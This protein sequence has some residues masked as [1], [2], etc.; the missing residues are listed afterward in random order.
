MLRS[1]SRDFLMQSFTLIPPCW[2]R[3]KLINWSAVC[4]VNRDPFSWVMIATGMQSI[5]SM[6]SKLV[7]IKSTKANQ[8]VRFNTSEKKEEIID[9]HTTPA[10][11]NKNRMKNETMMLQKKHKTLPT[12]TSS[13]LKCWYNLGSWNFSRPSQQSRIWRGGLGWVTCQL[14]P[15]HLSNAQND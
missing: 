4:P 15:H 6:R 13:A 9:Q 10:Q 2:D 7:T 3:Q 8:S 1:N 14:W 5:N 11:T 12:E